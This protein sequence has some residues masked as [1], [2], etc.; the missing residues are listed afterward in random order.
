LLATGECARLVFHSIG[1][2]EDIQYLL[3]FGLVCPGR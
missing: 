2:S 3:E 1:D